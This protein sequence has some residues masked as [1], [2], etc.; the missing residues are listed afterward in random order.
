MNGGTLS[1][2]FQVKNGATSTTINSGN[3]YAI[4]DDH[5]FHTYRFN[6][7]NN[8]GIAKVWANGVVVYTYNGTAGTP[9]YWTGA[10]NVTIGKDM[11]ATGRN[12]PVLDNLIIQKY[13]NALLPLKLLSFTAATKNKWAAVNWSSTEEINMAAYVV[14]RSSNGIV[15]APFCTVHAANGYSTGNYYTATDS[16]PTSTSRTLTSI[17]EP[18]S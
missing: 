15:F 18:D 16:L 4:P 3:I 13:A 14:E 5:S 8:T 7:D 2:S 9:L 11:D 6:Y 17:G 10:G 1:V 12:V